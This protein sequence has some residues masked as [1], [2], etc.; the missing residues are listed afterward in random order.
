MAEKE[1]KPVTV[2][3]VIEVI[4][5]NNTYA[6]YTALGLEDIRNINAAISSINAGKIVPADIRDK[7]L[8][9]GV[10]VHTRAAMEF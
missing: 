10:R 9:A 1:I 3:N 8:S 7:L 6:G 4:I 5:T 2:G